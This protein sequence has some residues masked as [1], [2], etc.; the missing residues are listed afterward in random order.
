M[1]YVEG[2][3]EARGLR[4]IAT[5]P[6]SNRRHERALEALLTL[7]FKFFWSVVYTKPQPPA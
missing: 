3:V 5:P 4:F 2:K 1:A 7:K 6:A